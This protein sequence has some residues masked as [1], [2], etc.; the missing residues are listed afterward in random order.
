VADVVSA[1]RKQRGRVTLCGRRDGALMACF[2]AALEPAVT[3]VALEEMRT[4][5][6]PLFGTSGVPINAASIV[7]GLL[8]S[9]GD[10]PD[11]FADIAPR[12][13]LLSAPIDAPEKL[14]TAV[15]RIEGRFSSD[16]ALLLDWLGK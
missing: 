9:Y 8:R 12:A 10:L 11:V 7:P 6:L 14:P 13:V 4:S 5:Y 15:R 3:R 16:P 2:A 1:V